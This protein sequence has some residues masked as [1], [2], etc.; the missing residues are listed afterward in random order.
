MTNE[1]KAIKWANKQVDRY[2]SRNNIDKNDPEHFDEIERIADEAL[3][4]FDTKP[5]WRR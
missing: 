3:N 4:E 2:C 5:L 1:D